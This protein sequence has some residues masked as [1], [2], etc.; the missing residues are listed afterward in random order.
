MSEGTHTTEF[1]LDM[2]LDRTRF[3]HAFEAQ[4]PTPCEA[5]FIAD[6]DPSRPGFI[7]FLLHVPL[8][9]KRELALFL[10]GY[11][12]HR[13]NGRKLASVQFHPIV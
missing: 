8:E 12:K 5:E 2:V 4:F 6:I 9:M 10:D 7:K 11:E 1:W 13:G 3:I